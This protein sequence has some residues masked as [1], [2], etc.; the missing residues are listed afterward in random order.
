MVFAAPDYR[1]GLGLGI[2][3]GI[4]VILG[5]IVGVLFLMRR[6]ALYVL[7]SIL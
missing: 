5:V 4:V 7:V 2:G 6:Q 3:F 1:L